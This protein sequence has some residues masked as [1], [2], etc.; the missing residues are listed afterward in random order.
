MPLRSIKLAAIFVV[1]C[2]ATVLAWER[3]YGEFAATFAAAAAIAVIGGA[4]LAVINPP[5]FA[6]LGK[7]ALLKQSSGLLLFGTMIEVVG[8]EVLIESSVFQHM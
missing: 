5:D 6:E 4:P 2:P 1:A 7:R 8:A 3:D